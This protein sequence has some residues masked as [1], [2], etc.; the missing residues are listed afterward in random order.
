M[1]TDLISNKKMVESIFPEGFD[2]G[3]PEL[4]NISIDNNDIKMSFN[5]REFPKAYPKKWNK[6]K[7]NAV[8]LVIELGDIVEFLSVGTGFGF[9]EELE[10]K[11]N[12]DHV[13]IEMSIGSFKLKLISKFL[14]IRSIQPY[15]DIRWE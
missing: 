5:L 6:E 2:L 14:T 8:H 3:L 7:F 10:I 13:L 4:S 1:W 11:S 12:N 15:D 9:L